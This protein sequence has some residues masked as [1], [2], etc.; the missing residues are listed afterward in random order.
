MQIAKLGRKI[1]RTMTQ[2]DKLYGT[3]TLGSRGQVVI[4][5]AARKEL[6]LKPGDQLLIMGK[7]GKVLGLVK[8]EQ[9]EEIMMM[10]MDLWSGSG[11]EKVIKAHAKKTFGKFLRSK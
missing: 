5:A 3:A 7:F 8:A 4:P 2:H 9:L 10:F 11:V 6:K 1:H